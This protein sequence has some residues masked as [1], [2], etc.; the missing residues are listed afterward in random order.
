NFGA[1]NP[2][3]IREKSAILRKH[4]ETVGRNFDEIVK[5]TSLNVFPIDAGD[6]PRTAT[7]RARG[8][9]DWDYFADLVAIGTDAQIADRM[10]AAIEAGAD[11]LIL[12]VPGVAYDLDL[13]GR[14]E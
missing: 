13:V 10:A 14:V 5:S 3:A 1:G 9:V 11:Y 6:D 4:C 8:P 12:Y 7:E 2:D